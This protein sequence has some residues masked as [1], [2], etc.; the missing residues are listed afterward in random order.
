MTAQDR[1]G[2]QSLAEPGHGWGVQKDLLEFEDPYT[3]A[4]GSRVLEMQSLTKPAWPSIDWLAEFMTPTNLGRI[5]PETLSATTATNIT[6]SVVLE[7]W[8]ETLADLESAV[9]W[10]D[11]KARS[12]LLRNPILLAAAAKVAQ[13][14][15]A[16]HGPRMIGPLTID[17][18]SDPEAPEPV[19][20]RVVYHAGD[21]EPIQGLSR[22]WNDLIVA[23]QEAIAQASRQIGLSPEEERRLAALLTVSV[24]VD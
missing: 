11:D 19:L 20:I 17:A 24:D 12:L 10:I 16:A 18:F 22:L 2:I 6:A 4:I 1:P 14:I 9:A 13:A 7:F 3:W 15:E 8:P 21:E 5:D 23:A